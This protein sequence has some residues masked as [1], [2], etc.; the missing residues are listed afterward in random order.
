MARPTG[1]I[2]G[3]LL[4]LGAACAAR[5]PQQTW[6][7]ERLDSIGGHVPEVVGAPRPMDERGRKALCFDGKADGVFLPVNPVAGWPWFT[8]EVLFKPDGDGS[9]EQRFLHIQDE[10]ERRILIE[11]RVTK[12]HTWALD[13]FLRA[14]DSDKLTLLDRS[15]VQST[16]GWYWVALVY[17]GKAMSHYVNGVEQ[18]QGELTFPPMSRGRISLGVRQN[19]I[20]WFKGCIAEARFTASALA[21]Q[22]LQA[23]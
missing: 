5:P 8:I 16:D 9:E 1:L 23:P 19:K 10:Q 22:D 14:T 15:K 4:S 13:T 6:R 12:E 21:P 11:T 17:D 18:L 2:L 7:L 3:L 20:H